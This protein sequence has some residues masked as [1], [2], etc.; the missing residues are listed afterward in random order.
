VRPFH[1]WSPLLPGLS[2]WSRIPQLSIHAQ[3]CN[4]TSDRHLT[5]RMQQLKNRKTAITDDNP[6]AIRDLACEQ[7][8]DLPGPPRQLLL[9][10]S[11]IRIVAEG[12]RTIRKGTLIEIWPTQYGPTTYNRATTSHWL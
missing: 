1:S 7:P 10:S 12:Q 5:H 6:P 8:Y 4:Q 9:R 3:A 11:P 2:C